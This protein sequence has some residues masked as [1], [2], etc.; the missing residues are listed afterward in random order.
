MSAVA[1]IMVAALWLAIG[2]LVFAVV[3]LA[4]Q[5]GLLHHRIPPSGAR[6]TADGPGLGEPAPELSGDTLDGSRLT[7]D[8]KN[9]TLVVFFSPTCAVCDALIPSVKALFAAEEHYLNGVLVSLSA[10]RS[11]N[12]GYASAHGLANVPILA[13]PELADRFGVR[14]AP[15]GV[16]V[17]ADG[18]VKSKGMIN[19]YEHVVSLVEAAEIGHPTLEHYMHSKRRSG[20]TAAESS[21]TTDARPGALG[22]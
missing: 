14:M 18:R 13:S 4:R 22:A 20:G 21:S 19:H 7:L 12:E 9:P 11:E 5:V 2:M 8:P 3:V 10:N 17:G 6:T 16:V 1:W 15:H